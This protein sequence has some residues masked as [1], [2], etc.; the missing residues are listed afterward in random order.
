MALIESLQKQDLPSDLPAG[1]EAHSLRLADA[2]A[3]VEL[4]NT[5]ALRYLGAPTDDV[6]DT[7]AYWQTPGFNLESDALLVRSAQGLVVAYAEF[8]NV[9]QPHTRYNV[10]GVV[11]PDFEGLGLGN[12]LYRWMNWRAALELPQSP[13]GAQVLF[14]QNA[15]ARETGAIE[16]MEAHGFS[17]AREYYHMHIELDQPPAA[18][19]VPAGY[20][21]RPYQGEAERTE[22]LRCMWEAFHDHWG[23]FDEPF[24]DYQKRMLHWAENLTNMDPALWYVAVKD[25]EIAAGCLCAA[26]RSEDPEM[27]WINTL[28]VRRA[29]RKQGLGLALLQ[30]SFGEFYRRG[31]KRAGLGVDAGSLTGAVHLYESAGMHTARILYSYHQVIREGKDLSIQALSA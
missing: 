12:Y 23:F 8:W 30:H 18:A 4:F 3:V 22:V 11:H 21:I 25:G 13:E 16:F 29:H 15:D 1:F 2:E 7:C 20:E 9:V 26:S 14:N 10:M 5:Y 6:E 31:K 17:R 24:E 27:G 28:G 19:V